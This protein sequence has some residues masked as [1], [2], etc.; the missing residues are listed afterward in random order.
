MKSK[1][2]LILELAEKVIKIC[3]VGIS[4][5][6][7]IIDFIDVVELT[8]DATSQDI[9]DIFSKFSK[10]KYE[11]IIISLPRTLFLMRFLQ[12]PSHQEAEIAKM[13]PFQLSKIVPYPLGEIIHDFSLA[14]IKENYSEIIIFLIHRKKINIILDAVENKRIDIDLITMSSRGLWQLLVYKNVFSGIAD[15]SFVMLIN[16]DKYSAEFLVAHRSGIIFSR[17]FSYSDNRSLNEGVNQSLLIFEKKFG[18]HAFAKVF[19][20]GNRHDDFINRINF[21]EAIPID[22]TIDFSITKKAK[23][24]IKDCSFSFASILGLSIDTDSGKFDFSPKPLKVKREIANKK[25]K[26]FKVAVV[27]LEII[28]ICGIFLSKYIY[29]RDSYREF[30][31]F[32]LEEIV[33]EAKE[34]DEVADKLKVLDKKFK[35]SAS[36]S[37]IIHGVVSAM[38]PG[39][40][41]TLFDFQ[42]NG[43]FSLKGHARDPAD[44]FAMEA[45]LNRLDFL[46]DVKIK[47]V[48]QVKQKGRMRVEFLILGDFK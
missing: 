12:L 39:I 45:S 13:L 48:S 43:E 42:E 5:K 37:E 15:S 27:V 6:R 28:L 8:Q 38:E 14:E 16:V 18:K 32:K 7:K 24:K 19:F 47:Y 34:L 36:F 40:Q 4:K 2:I 26:W 9:L 35:K 31:D 41:L 21:D 29:D 22:C 11:K 3:Q 17:A 30:L 1:K 46:K 10:T 33:V 23:D 25:K 20:T 44:V